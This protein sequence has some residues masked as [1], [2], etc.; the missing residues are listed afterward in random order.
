MAWISSLAVTTSR[1]SPARLITSSIT[2]GLPYSRAIAGGF[3]VGDSPPSAMS[4]KRTILLSSSF[5]TTM[6]RTWS[7]S[8]NSPIDA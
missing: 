7:M 4:P 8:V 1:F 2:T 6:S 5:F 3:L